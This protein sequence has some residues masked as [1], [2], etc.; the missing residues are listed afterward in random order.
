MFFA[1][2]AKNQNDSKNP[3]NKIFADFIVKKSAKV[4][5]GS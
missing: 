4:F 3:Y 5:E 2:G 1:Q